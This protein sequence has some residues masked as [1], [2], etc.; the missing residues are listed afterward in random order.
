VGAGFAPAFLVYDLVAMIGLLLALALAQGRCDPDATALMTAA[1]DRAANFD[2]TAAV[3][4]LTSAAQRGCEE[5]TLAVTFLRG[6]IASREA[7]RFGGSPESLL[8]V[9]QAIAELKSIVAASSG[10]SSGADIARYVL[11]AAA[12]A[13]QSERDS[14]SLFI[15]HA[16]QLESVRLAAGLTGAPIITAHEA[17]GDLWLQVHRY[18]DARRA[19]VL[20]RERIGATRRVT[21]GL[22]RT[23][24]R[25]KDVSEACTQYEALVASWTQ[26]GNAPQEIVDARAFL[27]EPRCQASARPQ[28]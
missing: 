18:E 7:Y 22:A 15:D 8:P 20:A 16:V 10:T 9:Q 1:S 24:E 25:V 12:A 26:Q 11:E 28:R 14:M 6:W 17:A 13:A 19:Y 27:R 5:A 23:A 4:R 3:G 21:V 2:L